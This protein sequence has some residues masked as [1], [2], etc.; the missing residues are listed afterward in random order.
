MKPDLPR[1]RRHPRHRPD[2]ASPGSFDLATCPGVNMTTGN[3]SEEACLTLVRASLFLAS[4]PWGACEDER[5]GSALAR[6]LGNGLGELDRFLNV[7]IEEGAGALAPTSF[8]HRGFARRHNTANKLRDI[9]A[10]MNLGSPDHERLR[11]IGRLREQFRRGG[12]ACRQK[13]F[14]SVAALNR[15]YPA[16]DEAVFVPADLAAICQFYAVTAQDFFAELT[17]FRSGI[18]ILETDPYFGV[19][20]V[21]CNGM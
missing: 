3:G 5:A 13:F 2:G 21:A 17:F 4:R 19:A 8:D 14:G 12:P 16:S 18:V 15:S 11:A 10:L 9:R 6:W 20:N 1:P 7:L